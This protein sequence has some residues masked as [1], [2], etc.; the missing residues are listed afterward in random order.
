MKE[1]LLS[2]I[3]GIIVFIVTTALLGA[4]VYY[5][6]PSVSMIVLLCAISGMGYTISFMLIVNH[7]Y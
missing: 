3:M 5:C 4:V 2:L 6:N 7:I 1:K